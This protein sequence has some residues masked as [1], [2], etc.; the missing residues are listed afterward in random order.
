MTKIP[1][2][3]VGYTLK[4]IPFI[5]NLSYFYEFIFLNTQTACQFIKFYQ[6]CQYSSLSIIVDW[7]YRLFWLTNQNFLSLVH[8]FGRTNLSYKLNTLIWLLL[9]LLFYHLW[10]ENNLS[11]TLK[12]RA[13]QCVKGLFVNIRPILTKW[14]QI[15]F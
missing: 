3:D 4:Y 6:L 13:F 5:L 14:S 11:C 8:L 10:S 7:T 2:F 1:S 9:I 12:W 15:P